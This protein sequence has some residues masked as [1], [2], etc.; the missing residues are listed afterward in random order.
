MHKLG[1]C[2]GNARLMEIISHHSEVRKCF[3]H[4]ED[5]DGDYITDFKRHAG[6]KQ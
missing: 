1:H 5:D 6:G 3:N 2:G 4:E